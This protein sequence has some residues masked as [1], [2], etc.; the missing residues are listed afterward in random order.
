MGGARGVANDE[1]Y[2]LMSE[3]MEIGETS[4]TMGIMQEDSYSGKEQIPTM[5][6]EA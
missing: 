4:R 6:M 1:G 2:G 3:G 5:G